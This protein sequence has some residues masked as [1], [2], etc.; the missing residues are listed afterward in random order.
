MES[1]KKCI[2]IAVGKIKPELVLKNCKVINVFSHEIIEQDI[3]INQGKIIGLGEYVGEK[4]IDIEGRYV[5]PGLIDS[6]VH[7]ES[8]M[9]TPNQFSRVIVPRG[10]TTII[11]DP[12]EIANVCGITGIE[13]MIDTSDNL[14]INIYFM[15]PSCVPATSFENSGAILKA[16]ELNKLIDNERVLGLGELMDYPSV[17]AGRKDI[18]K[19]VYIADSKIIDGHGPN[20]SGKELNGYV[21]AGVRTEHECSTIEEMINRLRLGLYIAIREG[22]AARNLE[23]LVRGVNRD[24][25]RRCMF[26]TDDRHPDDIIKYGHIDNN[27]RLA[28]KRGIDP[29]TAIQMATL[30]V[31]ECYKIKN[32]GAI[33]PGYKADMIVVDDLKEFNVIKVFKNGELVAKD[34]KAL[35]EVDT[36][37]NQDVMNT[38]N[39]KKVSLDDLNI[40]LKTDIVNVIRLL[41]HSLV[42]E[43]VIR[44]IDVSEEGIFKYNSNLDVLKLAVIERHNAT[45]NIGLGLVENFRLKGGAIASTIAHDS[46]NI[47]VIGDNNRDMLV[48]I[49]E[50]IRLE[51]GVTIC[52]RG[53]VLKSLALP[54]AGIMSNKPM[55]D[56]NKDLEEML[57]IAYNKL[58]VNK[59]LD[60]FMTLSFLALPV[61][62][63]I[64]VTDMGLFDVTK[65]NF[66][67]INVEDQN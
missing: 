66:T 45:G 18:L 39:V 38:V 40:H 13:Y 28:I 31:S 2:D 19:K 3:A 22:S 35:F 51:G 67:K 6:H 9:V 55:E 17:I 50:V 64:K 21:T 16:E 43:K 53:K 56:V 36:S 8:S 57:N 1:I 4:E 54:I 44:K 25:A 37:N 63:E 49:N 62:P 46:H 14:P 47:V 20:I 42:T 58:G 27:V 61:I 24:N 15:L 26:C 7:I 29:I 65:F 23:A 41:P 34:K 48:A 30:N 33:A 10:T 59:D 32:I 5:A 12:H 52:S 60:P 11:A